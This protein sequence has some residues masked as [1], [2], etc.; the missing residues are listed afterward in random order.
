[1]L[2]CVSN[3]KIVRRTKGGFGDKRSRHDER[4]QGRTFS[5]PDLPSFLLLS[6]TDSSRCSWRRPTNMRR[7]PSLAAVGRELASTQRSAWVNN[8]GQRRDGTMTGFNRPERPCTD[9]R[10]A[11]VFPP[12]LPVDSLTHHRQ[13]KNRS[14]SESFKE[15]RTVSC[16]TNESDK[17]SRRF[18]NQ[19]ASPQG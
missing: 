13:S 2:D 11:A 5:A 18:S 12:F 8:D 6:S 14:R 1:M 4:L 10:H 17:K 15:C 16:T 19:T 3:R 7:N 9:Q